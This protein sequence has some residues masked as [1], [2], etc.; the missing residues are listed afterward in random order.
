VPIGVGTVD[1][2][3][4]D[5]QLAIV[6]VPAVVHRHDLGMLQCGGDVGFADEACPKVAVA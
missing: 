2:L 6:G 3:H 1:E 4:G 5:P